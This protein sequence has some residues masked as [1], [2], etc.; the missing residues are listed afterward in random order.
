MKTTAQAPITP[1]PAPVVTATEKSPQKTGTPLP[2][3]PPIDPSRLEEYQRW[4]RGIQALSARKRLNPDEA[5]LVKR[6]LAQDHV[7]PDTLGKI[8]DYMGLLT[9][10][11]RIEDF[12]YNTFLLTE[13]YCQNGVPLEHLSYNDTQHFIEAIQGLYQ[14]RHE[15][16]IKVERITTE[17]ELDANVAVLRMV[18]LLKDMGDD[19]YRK[20][21]VNK[22]YHTATGKRLNGTCLRN[23][24]FAELLRENH[25][26]YPEIERYVRDRGA[27]KNKQEVKALKAYLNNGNEHTTAMAEGWL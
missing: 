7:H 22:E 27:P 9:A 16:D 17:E 3:P 15:A 6:I 24:A 18:M 20:A 11:E 2:V 12:D 1:I 26:S 21:T 5:A 14:R 23:K 10:G 25:G 4:F 13:R 19:T 8:S